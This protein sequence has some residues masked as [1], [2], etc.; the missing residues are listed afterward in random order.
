MPD[1]LTKLRNIGIIAHIDAGKTTLTERMLF[2]GGFSHRVGEVDKGT[3][4]TDSDPEEQQRGITILSA[5]VTF[6]WKDVTINLIDTP[7]H[8]DFTAEV[9]RS[10]R[11]LDGGVVVFSAREGVEAQSETVWHQADKYRVPRIAFINKMDREGADYYETLDEIRQRLAAN[12]LPVNLPVGAGPPH[13]ADAFRGVIDLVR[14]KMLVFADIKKGGRVDESDVSEQLREDAEMWRAQML[15]ELSHFDDELIALLLDEEPVPEALIH[16]VLR[17]ATLQNKITPVLC[18]SAL[19]GIG[20]QLVLDAVAAYL[21]S[22]ADLPPVQ[23]TD[24]AKNTPAS[25]KP[26]ASEPFCGLVF[27]IQP[28]RHGDLH[29]VRVYSGELKAN[30]RVYNPAKDKKEN[31]PQLWRIQCDRRTQADRVSAGDIIGVI[32]LRHSVTGDTLCDTREPILLESI[33]FPETVISMA[34]EPETSLERKKL[35]DVLEM[36]KRQDPTFLAKESEETGQTLISGMGELHLEVIKHR[37]LRDFNLDVKVHNPR[38]SYRETVAK[39]VEVTGHCHRTLAGQTLSAAVTIR[40]EPFD[41]GPKS[42]V[43]QADCGDALPAEFLSAALETLGEHGE[44]SGSLGF[45]LMHVRMT[46]LGGK[47]HETE[48]NDLAFRIAATD[49]FERGL[50]EGGIVLLEPIMRLEVTTPEDHYGEIVSDLQQR[51]A[52]ITRTHARGKN[53]VIESRAPLASLF[54][55]SNAM[56]SLTQGRATCTMEPSSYGPAPPDVLAGFL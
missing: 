3:T 11:V 9:E 27:K 42:V 56:R 52:I 37:L 23:G 40:M 51:R 10:L 13:L 38:V 54:G 18:G 49:A 5:C 24:P 16:R 33:T 46:I 15:E 2:Y 50:R 8:V 53:T 32:G 29:Y 48:S 19:D 43:V 47:V 4:H 41:E 39:R 22:P 36:L 12:P 26:S 35:A 21:P 7:G 25:R 45:P 14:M 34:I 55:Y 31:I 6:P 28:A 30:S 1:D 17:Q 44:G 20:V